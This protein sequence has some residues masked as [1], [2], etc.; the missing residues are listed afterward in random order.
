MQAVASA[1]KTPINP[2]PF[3]PYK[4][5]TTGRWMPPRLSLRRQAQLA[6]ESYRK[7]QFVKLDRTL[8]EQGKMESVK[9]GKMK[10]RMEELVTE[11]GG[12]G[13][14]SVLQ[15]KS[16]VAPRADETKKALTLAKALA[17]S[18]GPY[19]GRSLKNI[20]KG[21]KAEREA[22]G[23][24]QETAQKMSAMAKTVEAWRKVR[25]NVSKS[26]NLFLC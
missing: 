23:K 5:P 10:A 8:Q 18:R 19:T 11:A 26:V 14:A 20:F 16:S 24:K 7:G 21:T 17:A 15:N 12:E 13:A 4:S 9:L 22:P 3:N 2:E 25:V 1:G 6:K